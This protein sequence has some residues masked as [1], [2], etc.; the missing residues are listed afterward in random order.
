M[1]HGNSDVVNSFCAGKPGGVPVQMHHRRAAPSRQYFHLGQPG[2]SNA[3]AQGLQ[4]RFLSGKTGRENHAQ[5]R[6]PL[7]KFSLAGCEYPLQK[8]LRA[9]LV[10]PFD[11]PHGNQV[12]SN[13]KNHLAFTPPMPPS[14][15][16]RTRRHSFLHLSIRPKAGCYSSTR[17]MRRLAFN[18]CFSF[19]NMLKFYVITPF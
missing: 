8:T 19:L 16:A 4:N 1:G 6:A 15:F 2:R 7:Q 14:Y 12:H 5:P 3:T 9:A 13:P 11:P 18:P 10:G 17:S